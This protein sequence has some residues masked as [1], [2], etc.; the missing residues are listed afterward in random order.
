MGPVLFSGLQTSPQGSVSLVWYVSGI[1][2]AQPDK[3]LTLRDSK[4]FSFEASP[5]CLSRAAPRQKERKKDRKTERKTE[6][7]YRWTSD[8]SAAIQKQKHTDVQFLK[9][10]EC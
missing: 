1:F 5:L 3:L 2:P 9:H 10:S 6:S 8:E 4:I 7:T